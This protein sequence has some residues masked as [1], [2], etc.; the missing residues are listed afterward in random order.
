MSGLCVA[1]APVPVRVRAPAPGTVWRHAKRSSLFQV[2]AMAIGEGGAIEDRDLVVYTDLE[3]RR[4]WVRDV[5]QFMDG[6]FVAH[7]LL[8]PTPGFKDRVGGP[9]VTGC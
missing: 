8:E 5:R 7:N 4:T 9:P 6:R 1:P 2:V 3:T